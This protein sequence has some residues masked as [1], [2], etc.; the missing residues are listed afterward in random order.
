MKINW[1]TSIVIA[2]IG[3]I[4]FIMY[5]VITVNTDEKYDYDLVT[6][7][8]YKEELRYQTTIDKE[9]NSKAL[10]QNVTWQKTEKG[11]LI[12]FP[13]TFDYKHI[14]GKLFLYRPSN[15]QLDFEIP[16]SLSSYNLLIPDNRMLD[17]RWN[18][19]VDWEYQ[20]MSYL[21]KEELIY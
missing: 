16:I 12:T 14:T 2:F 10:K 5:F 7:E 13:D 17:G 1:G 9:K 20:N 3:F 18:I 11:M 6:D 4:S 21:F 19:Y 8:Y 15:R